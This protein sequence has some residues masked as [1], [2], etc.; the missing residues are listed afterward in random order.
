[1]ATAI[2]QIYFSKHNIWPRP[3]TD[4]RRTEYQISEIRKNPLTMFV[5][6][7]IKV[8]KEVMIMPQPHNNPNG[9][10]FPSTTGNPSGGGRGN[11]NPKR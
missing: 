4:K 10:G 11:N 9:A 1:M 2:A 3:N 7:Y 8:Q 6:F 5:F